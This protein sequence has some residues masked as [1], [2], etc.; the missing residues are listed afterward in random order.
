[1]ISY[2]KKQYPFV[3][4]SLQLKNYYLEELIRYLFHY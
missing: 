3:G 4:A 1:M 2:Y